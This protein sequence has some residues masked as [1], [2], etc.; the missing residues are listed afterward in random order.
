M[1]VR[2]MRLL[3]ISLKK[4]RTHKTKDFL[5]EGEGRFTSL[6]ANVPLELP[7]QR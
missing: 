3:K 7:L 4:N 2:L 6:D 5:R 1:R